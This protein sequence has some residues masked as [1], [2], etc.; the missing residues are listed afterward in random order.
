MRI[1]KYH[2]KS[3]RIEYINVRT[4]EMGLRTS[5]TGYAATHFDFVAAQKQ[6]KIYVLNNIIKWGR[7]YYNHFPLNE[8]K[9]EKTKSVMKKKCSFSKRQCNAISFHY[10]RCQKVV[11]VSPS[12]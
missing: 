9:Q 6:I 2:K 1:K 7:V 3:K 4:Y 10:M 12:N 11:F 5:S 8:E